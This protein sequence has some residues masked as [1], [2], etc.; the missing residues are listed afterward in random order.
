MEKK[1]HGKEDRPSSLVNSSERYMRKKKLTSL[2]EPRADNSARAC[3]DCLALPE[4]ALA[5]GL[6][7]RVKAKS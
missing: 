4:F 3:S 2:P 1:C 7:P 6:K 5:N